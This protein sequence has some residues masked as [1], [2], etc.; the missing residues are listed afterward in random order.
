MQQIIRGPF[1]R[2]AAPPDARNQPRNRD[3]EQGFGV[4]GWVRDADGFRRATGEPSTGDAQM[5]SAE[6]D[7]TDNNRMER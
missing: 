4:H 7:I 5:G 1:Q 6:S 3:D 2:K